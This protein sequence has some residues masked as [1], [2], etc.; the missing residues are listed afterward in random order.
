MSYRKT[1]ALIAI[2]AAALCASSAATAQEESEGFML[3]IVELHVKAGHDDEFRAGIDAWKKCY[4]KNEGKGSWNVWRRQHGH[5]NVYAATFRMANWAELDSPDPASRACRKVALEK[6]TPHTLG[7][8]NNNSYAEFMPEY[9]RSGEEVD[10]IWVTSFRAHD[11][12]LMMNVV[13]KVSEAMKQVEGQP[14]GYWYNVAG[15]PEDAADYFVV[16][17]YEN[18]AAMD[19]ER[20]GVWS[21]VTKAFGEEEAESLR[22]DFRKSLDAAWG[23]AYRRVGDLSHSQ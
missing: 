5:G 19:V 15:G 21:I 12:R 14:R 7:E 6:I 22:A 18:F 1:L 20:E 9:S 23:Y 13:K 2:S 4:I 17:P 3:S 11:G 8:L 16:T 10:V